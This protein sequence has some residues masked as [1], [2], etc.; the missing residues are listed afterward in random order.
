M[1]IFLPN[2]QKFWDLTR[3]IEN[4]GRV[5]RWTETNRQREV[6]IGTCLYTKYQK[7]H[8]GGSKL[9]HT[10]TPSIISTTPGVLKA[11]KAVMGGSGIKFTDFIF[12]L[13]LQ[14]I[15]NVALKYHGYYSR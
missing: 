9:V 12:V 2:L 14:N 7:Y 15:E 1:S 4:N 3:H 8:P 5:L 11:H 6:Q 13:F 10:C